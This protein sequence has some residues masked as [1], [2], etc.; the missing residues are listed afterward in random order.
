MLRA[1]GRPRRRFPTRRRVAGTVVAALAA[2]LTACTS[3]VSGPG[4]AGTGAPPSGPGATPDRPNIVFVLTDDLSWN[5]VPYMPHVLALEHR[6]MTFTNYTVA[7]SLC[8]PSRA[9]IFTGEFPHNTKVLSNTAPGGGWDRFRT[10]GDE[11]HTFATSLEAAGY[12]TALYGKYLNAY[13]PSTPSSGP[14]GGAYVP[15][16]WTGWGG[17]N[18]GGYAEFNYEMGVGVDGYG[19]VQRFGSA[20]DDYL[21]SVIERFG[22]QFAGNSIGAGQPFFLELASFAPHRP[23]VPAPR[24]TGTFAGLQAPRPPSFGRLP[25]DPPPWMRSFAPLSNREQGRI[26]AEFARRVASVQ[27]V[28]RMIGDLE[29]LLARRN[30]LQNTIFVFS[31]DNGYHMG[32]HDLWPGKQTA[33]DTD[34]RV[35]LI[36]AGPHIAQ[37]VT[38]PVMAENI[39]LAPTFDALAGAPVPRSVDGRS[40]VPLLHGQKVPWRSVALVEH[41]RSLPSASDPDAQLPKQGNPPSYDALRTRSYL[42]VRY[43]NGGALEYYNLR[44]DPQELH[45]IAASLSPARVAQLEKTLAALTSCRE[46]ACWRAAQPSA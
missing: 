40:L 20:P 19:K 5:L 15:P 35:P 38:S 6:G 7:D 24:D 39:D 17:V 32:E 21:T 42:F 11:R 3:S 16:G 36:V 26:N 45:N 34:I 37:G 12:R 8:C 25:T 33:Y 23:Y 28:D 18:G 43:R 31:S 2:L 9:T 27:A 22:M 29:R 1:A 30:E 14:L 41:S 13:Q 44:A 10:T 46:A 4:A